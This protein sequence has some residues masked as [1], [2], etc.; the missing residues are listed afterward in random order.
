LVSVAYYAQNFQHT[1]SRLLAS[2]LFSQ[3]LTISTDFFQSTANSRPLHKRQNS[4]PASTHARNH[5]RNNHNANN[6]INGKTFPVPIRLNGGVN[7]INHNNGMTNV[8]EL[9]ELLS[10]YSQRPIAE[11]M[12]RIEQDYFNKIRVASWNLDRLCLQKSENLGVKEVICRTILENN[13]T[14]VSISAAL[15]PFVVTKKKSN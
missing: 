11:N 10:V 12:C 8:L 4:A 5:I 9:F 1:T 3:S 7:S 15:L 2:H 14:I 13:L 6:C